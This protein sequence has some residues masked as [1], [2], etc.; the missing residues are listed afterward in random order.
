MSSFLLDTHI[1]L[2]SLLSPERLS[3]RVTDELENQKN[4]LWLSPITT[5]EVLILAEKGK[6]QLESEPVAWMRNVLEAL[7]FKKAAINHEVSFLSRG[8]D[9][10][11]KDPADRFIAATAQVYDLILVTADKTIIKSARNF[12]VLEN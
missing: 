3:R 1:L 10:P 11:H 7:P 6:I 4:E 2:W 9:L 8:I 5:W 12:A